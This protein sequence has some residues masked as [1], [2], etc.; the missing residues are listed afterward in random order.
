MDSRSC[1]FP[2]APLST[3]LHRSVPQR[4]TRRRQADIGDSER[5]R[6]E[7]SRQR[8]ARSG[9]RLRTQNI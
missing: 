3:M 8:C 1:S 4:R 9:K 6:I 7:D 5:V 2:H